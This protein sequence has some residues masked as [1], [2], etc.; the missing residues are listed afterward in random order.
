MSKTSDMIRKMFG[1]GDAKRDAGLTTPEDII[2]YDDI[3]YDTIE[4]K[5]QMLDV[6]RPKA[7]EGKLPVILSIHGGGWVYGDKDVYQ[8]YCMSLAQRGFAVVNYSYRLAPEY[9]YPA[10]FEDTKTVCE[11]ILDNAE[12]Y[13]FDTENIFGVG[14]S[15]GAHMLAMLCCALTNP[16]YAKTTGFETAKGFM[17]K[18]VALNCGAFLITPSQEADLTTMLMGDY[19]P[20]GGTKE[21]FELISPVKHLTADFPPVFIMTCPGDFLNAQPANV[22]PELERLKVQ[23]VYR[24]YGDAKNE[25]AH[26]FHCNIRLPEAKLCNDEETAFFRSFLE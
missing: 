22:I 8:W 10:S 5:W 25:L 23:F 13:G 4:P 15:A 21:E 19:L 2:R 14:D 26:V 11:W 3:R 18:A 1:E 9:K 24:H 7:S 12:K 20:N 16:D 17:F 6:Y